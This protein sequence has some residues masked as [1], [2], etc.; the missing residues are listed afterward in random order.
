MKKIPQI[1]KLT[2]PKKEVTMVLGIEK[3]DNTFRA[4]WQGTVYLAGTGCAL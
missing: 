3:Q 2:L 4:K 1:T